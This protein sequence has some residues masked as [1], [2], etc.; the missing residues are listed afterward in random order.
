M[1]RELFAAIRHQIVAALIDASEGALN[2]IGRVVAV[3]ASS[4]MEQA[5]E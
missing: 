3:A 4:I 5:G 2:S 1:A